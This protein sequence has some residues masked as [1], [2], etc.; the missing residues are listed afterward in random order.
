M[1]RLRLPR[2]SIASLRSR[3]SS[4]ERLMSLALVAG[5]VVV[6][7]VIAAFVLIA[8]ANVGEGMAVK[9]PPIP[10]ITDSSQ[11][12]APTTTR[13]PERPQRPLLPATGISTTQAEAVK[14]PPKP[15]P[16]PKPKPP[17]PAPGPPPKPVPTSH[18]G[19]GPGPVEAD[20]YD[21]CSPEGAQA[22]TKH[23]HIALVCRD[24]RWHFVGI[25]R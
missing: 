18:P 9:V 22:V 24:G 12:E 11:P 8:S 19:P 7:G 16:A 20:P 23:R 10:T 5:F 25:A 17:K 14:V 13:E 21:R 2:I 15:K 3:V 4:E 6:I 1:P